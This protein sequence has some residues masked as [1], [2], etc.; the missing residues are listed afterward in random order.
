MQEIN[1][2]ILQYLSNF[3]NNKFIWEYIWI[4]ADL[5]MFFLPIFLLWFWLYYRF[6]KTET[7]NIFN[8]KDKKEILLLIFYSTILALIISLII[9][10]FI[11][12]ERPENHINE[13]AKLLMEH[14]PDA[15]F[16]SDHAT[17][18][19]AFL[20]SLFFAGYK[21]IWLY[22]MP[23]VI[24]MNISRIVAWVHWPFDILAG[25]I[26]WISSSFLMFKYL[27]EIKL[28]KVLNKFILNIMKLIKL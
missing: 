9:Q 19:F 3:S 11:N 16:P 26:I 18:S 8:S 25:A 20:A 21:K 28:I 5:P 24:I 14:L 27:K 22:F 2:N 13:S 10:Q 1:K 23:F 6:E 4:L 17:V 15:S 12:I 7:N